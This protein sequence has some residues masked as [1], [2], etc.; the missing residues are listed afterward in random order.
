MGYAYNF[1]PGNPYQRPPAMGAPG[2]ASYGRPASPAFPLYS[3][4]AAPAAFNAFTAPRFNTTL[5]FNGFLAPPP[6]LPT[7]GQILNPT[8]LPGGNPQAGFATNAAS[9]AQKPQIQN[10][11][12]TVNTGK[13][14]S[15]KKKNIKKF[16]LT[17][18]AVMTGMLAT[19]ALGFL[20]LRIAYPQKFKAFKL[21][22]EEVVKCFNSGVSAWNKTSSKNPI[23]KGLKGFEAFMEAYKNRPKKVDKPVGYIGRLWNAFLNKQEPVVQQVAA[24]VEEPVES[25]L[26]SKFPQVAA[27]QEQVTTAMKNITEASHGFVQIAQDLKTMSPELKDVL[28]QTKGALQGVQPGI[29]QFNA[30]FSNTAK[31]SATLDSLL[32]DLKPQ[33]QETVSNMQTASKTAINVTTDAQAV[34]KNA[35]VAVVKATKQ[36]SETAKQAQATLKEVKKGVTKTTGQLGHI[37]AHTHSTLT[38][39]EKGVAEATGHMGETAK[40]AQAVMQNADKAIADATGHIG[41]TTAQAQGAISDVQALTASAQAALPAMVEAANHVRDLSARANTVTNPLSWFGR[42]SKKATPSTDEVFHDALESLPEGA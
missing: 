32:T 25:T 36:M 26:L 11:Y 8:A 17:T 35:D 33:I 38:K 10:H 31:A 29:E 19:I 9:I 16:L 21:I 27:L 30:T 13:E 40:Q 1:N 22:D 15:S 6:G 34:I 42:G 41:Q 5:P 18:G 2:M 12:Y 20:G 4:P 28:Q 37:A 24:A 23:N 14:P 3:R 7:P 39:V